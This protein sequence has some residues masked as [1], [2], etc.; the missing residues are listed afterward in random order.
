MPD[1]RHH[2]PPNRIERARTF[3]RP[4][5]PPEARLWRHLRDRALGGL[6]FR[7]Q[8]TLGPYV[9]DFYCPA[10]RLVVELDGDSHVEQAE[11]DERRTAW[12]HGQGYR[13]IRF[14]NSD[15]FRDI[16]AVLEGTA[17]ACS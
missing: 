11:H 13:V 17:A 9:A 4:L 6:K 14:N 3:R 2:T 16:E 7:R 12:L 10:A 15:V 5:T 8:Y 1:T